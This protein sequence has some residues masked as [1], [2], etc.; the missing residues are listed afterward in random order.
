MATGAELEEI[1][2]QLYGES[3]D[4]D[5]RLAELLTGLDTETALALATSDLLNAAQVYI[6][7]FRE[8]P[9]EEI[10][11]LLLLSPASQI[12]RGIKLETAEFADIVMGFDKTKRVFFIGVWYIDTFIKAFTG[13]GAYDSANAYALEHCSR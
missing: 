5:I 3:L 4:D 13:E 10:Y 1:A 12:L 7:A 6:Y 8:V 11:D 2:E 9:D